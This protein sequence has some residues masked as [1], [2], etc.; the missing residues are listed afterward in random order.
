MKIKIHRLFSPRTGFN[1][2]NGAALVMVVILLMLILVVSGAVILITSL[3]NT[4]TTDAVYEKQADEAAEA[5]MQQTLNILRGNGTGEAI[6]FREAAIRSLSN[7]PNDWMSE[8]RLSNWLNYTYPTSQPDRV[9]C[10][11]WP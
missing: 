5:G 2:E 10:H 6:S 3:S 8:A 11:R 1:Q 4:S 9:P 7:Q